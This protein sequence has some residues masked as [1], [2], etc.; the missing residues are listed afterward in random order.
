GIGVYVVNEGEPVFTFGPP[1][2][3]SYTDPRIEIKAASVFG[4]LLGGIVVEGG[5]LPV[6]IEKCGLSGH[7]DAGIR[8]MNIGSGFVHIEDCIV[9]GTKPRWDG[10]FGDGILAWNAQNVVVESCILSSNAR[11]G[12][13]AV[14][15]TI[16][17]ANT[18]INCN[19]IDLAAEEFGGVA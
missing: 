7:H 6:C 5:H 13:G 2:S 11:A 3:P 8:L 18:D 9:L 1:C 10:L 14:A 19:T 12:L 16:Y 15:S 17:V 4:A